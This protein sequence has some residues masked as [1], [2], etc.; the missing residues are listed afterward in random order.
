ML[1]IFRTQD[2]FEAAFIKSVLDSA[3]IQYFVF[4]EHMNTMLGGIV[5]D[6]IAACRFM[7]AEDEFDDACDVLE[8]A[9]V[10]GKEAPDESKR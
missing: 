10:F 6:D 2:P 9:G 5:G 8:D 3:Q 1:E 4:G 7:V